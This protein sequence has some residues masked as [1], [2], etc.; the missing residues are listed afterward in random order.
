[1]N[2][3]P[4]LIQALD[5]FGFSEPEMTVYVT[6]LKFGAQPASIVAKQSGLKRGHTYNIL[7]T[8]KDRGVVQEF[9]KGN[10]MHFSACAPSTLISLLERREE[11]LDRKKKSLLQVIPELERIR[12]PY[13][14]QPKVRFFH[15][16]EGI[17]AIYEDTLQVGDKKLFS[18][19][20]FDHFFP[21]ENDEELNAWMW[22]YCQR[23]AKNGIWYNGILNKSSTSDDAFK[24]RVK[25]KRHL[26]M[27]TNVYLPVEVNIYDNKVAIISSSKDMV[28]LIIED[29]PT[30]D[31][32]RSLHQ[33]FWA[34]LPDYRI[35]E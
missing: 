3:L 33:A 13:A 28:G 34:F 23:R 7:S 2:L 16:V 15:G 11:E 32:F 22:R 6:L 29:K 17:K 1:M 30:A 27:L 31:T 9:E 35:E 8:L 4:T 19:G 25:E 5:S 10:V 21:K 12:N 18:L 20:D 26:K 24:T 14:Q